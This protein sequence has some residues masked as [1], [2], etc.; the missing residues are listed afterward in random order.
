MA[1]HTSKDS[2]EKIFLHLPHGLAG[3]SPTLLALFLSADG[4][5]LNSTANVAIE[6]KTSKGSRKPWV[7]QTGMNTVKMFPDGSSEIM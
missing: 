7:P 2:A 5:A 6:E 4:G 1:W 3:L